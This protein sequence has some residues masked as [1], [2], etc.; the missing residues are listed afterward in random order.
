[1]ILSSVW[2]E[3]CVVSDSVAVFKA[4][5][6][7]QTLCPGKGAT[8]GTGHGEWMWKSFGVRLTGFRFCLYSGPREFPEPTSGKGATKSIS[9]SWKDYSAQ[10][11]SAL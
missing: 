2:A 4:L 9:L 7:S 6:K 10:T 11:V 8:Q 1:M 3:L 5:S